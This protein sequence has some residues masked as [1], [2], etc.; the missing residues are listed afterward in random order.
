[1]AEVNEI[2]TLMNT[3]RKLALELN[4]INAPCFQAMAEKAGWISDR[5]SGR[6]GGGCVCGEMEG[7][8]NYSTNI[9]E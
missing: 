8:T 5:I 1:V 9:E 6:L 7:W 2:G 3:M 4:D